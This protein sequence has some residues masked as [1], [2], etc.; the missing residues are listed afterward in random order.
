M[1]KLSFNSAMFIL[2]AII[3]KTNLQRKTGA[4]NLTRKIG[5]DLWRR[6]LARVPWALVD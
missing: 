6:F 2:G 3:F 5:A 1:P 4:R